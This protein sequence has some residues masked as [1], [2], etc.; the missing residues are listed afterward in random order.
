MD[1]G[2]ALTAIF[3]PVVPLLCVG[4]TTPTAASMEVGG[5]EPFF[6]SIW[7]RSAKAHC[8]SFN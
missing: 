4:Q 1:T 3:R 5:A 6:A 2:E 8:S 7:L